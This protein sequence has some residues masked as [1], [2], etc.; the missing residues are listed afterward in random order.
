MSAIAKSGVPKDA[1]HRGQFHGL[2]TAEPGKL[3]F[4]VTLSVAATCAPFSAPIA[5]SRPS[6]LVATVAR[7]MGHSRRPRASRRPALLLLAP[8]GARSGSHSH[9]WGSVAPSPRHSRGLM[10]TLERATFAGI[11]PRCALLA[12]IHSEHRVPGHFRVLHPA[13]GRPATPNGHLRALIVRFPV[14]NDPFIR[15]SLY[16]LGPKPVRPGWRGPR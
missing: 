6:R 4:R 13:M 10:A 3:V 12:V 7:A 14:L 15:M 16:K 8:C 1:T 9:Y 11:R 5:P 2:V